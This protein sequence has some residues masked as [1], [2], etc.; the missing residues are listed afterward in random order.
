MNKAIIVS[1]FDNYSYNVRMKYV[2]EQLT[3]KG[4]TCNLITSDFDHRDK[5]T[6]ETDRNNVILIN[7]PKY[8]TNLSIKRIYSHY[9]FSKNVLSKLCELNP[10]LIY[11]CAPPNFLFYFV[12]KYANKGK[13]K[14]IYDI[15]DMW[16]ESLPFGKKLEFLFFPI[17]KVWAFLRNHYINYCDGIICECNLF[18]NKLI[19]KSNQ[20]KITTIY[21]CKEDV[22]LNKEL[23]LDIKKLKF[24]YLGSI[25]NIIDIDLIV[26]ILVEVRKFREVEF[27]IIGN[28]EKK[29]ELIEKCKKNNI[30]YHFMGSIFNE[31]KKQKIVNKCHFAFNIMKDSV[32]VGATM[33]SLEYFYY[34]MIVINSIPADTAELIDEYCSGFNVNDKNYKSVAIKIA[35]MQENDFFKMKKNSRKLFNDNFSKNIFLKKFNDFLDNTIG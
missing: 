25:N 34:G 16:P 28:G 12:S 33:K 24:L 3:L 31:N 13:A 10:N 26:R 1:C 11:V 15:G 4:Y 6:Y 5:C 8:K 17:L 35:E 7:V 27:Y 19:N 32:F 23:K 2:E 29:N 21:L 20:K 30:N 9:I 18:K 14:I 22:Y